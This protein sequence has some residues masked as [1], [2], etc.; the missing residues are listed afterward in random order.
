MTAGRAYTSFAV[1]SVVALGATGAWS[2]SQESKRIMAEVVQPLLNATCSPDKSVGWRYRNVGV[3]TSLAALLILKHPERAPD[4]C[5][6]INKSLAEARIVRKNSDA[7]SWELP[8]G[9]AELTS[10]A[11]SLG[12]QTNWL[13]GNSAEQSRLLHVDKL[14]RK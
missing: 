9:N 12:V 2:Q 14:A 13:S 6:V 7:H 3:D 8:N 5:A 4:V 1:A 10:L 11:A